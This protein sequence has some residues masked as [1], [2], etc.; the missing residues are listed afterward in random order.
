MLKI[1]RNHLQRTFS[2]HLSKWAGVKIEK[3]RDSGGTRGFH[4][5]FWFPR[6]AKQLNHARAWLPYWW[7]KA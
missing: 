6:N 4:L 3:T 7:G 5:F 2:I 1:T